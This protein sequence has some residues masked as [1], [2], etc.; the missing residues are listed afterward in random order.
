MKTIAS[1]DHQEN[2]PAWNDEGVRSFEEMVLITQSL[3]EVGQIV[4]SSI[5]P[6]LRL[7]KPGT[8]KALCGMG[9]TPLLLRVAP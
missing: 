4:A 3:K 8:F 7:H 5:T 2:I 6:I 1:L 9:K